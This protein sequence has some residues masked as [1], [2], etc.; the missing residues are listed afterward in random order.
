MTSHPFILT[1][2]ILAGNCFGQTIEVMNR[3]EKTS[4]T[5]A[6]FHFEQGAA[7][8]CLASGKADAAGTVQV[9]PGKFGQGITIGS[10]GIRIPAAGNLDLNRGTIEFWFRAPDVEWFEQ[11]HNFIVYDTGWCQPGNLKIWW[12][13]DGGIRFDHHSIDGGYMGFIMAG[14]PWDTK[15]HHIAARW[16]S[17]TGIA[18]FVDGVLLNAKAGSWSPV[19]TTKPSV[20]IGD[21][22][23]P[24]VMDELRISNKSLHPPGTHPVQMTIGTDAAAVTG[25]QTVLPVRVVFKNITDQPKSVLARVSIK[26]YFQQTLKEEEFQKELGADSEAAV[27][28]P[29]PVDSAGPYVKVRVKLESKTNQYKP[30]E[31]EQ[32]CFTEVLSGPRWR[33]NLNG[34]WQT[35]AGLWR[36]MEKVPATWSTSQIL[37]QKDAYWPTHAKWYRKS[38]DL[39]TGAA[40]KNVTLDL[41]GVRF[42]A[43]V[44]LNG[45]PLGQYDTDQ[46]P[47][48]VDLTPA[49]KSGQTNELVLGVTDWVSCT[50]PED[51]D[52]FTEAASDA[53]AVPGM[54]F[55]RACS[56]VVVPAGITDPI[57]VTIHSPVSIQDV[58][59]TPSVRQKNLHVRMV[60]KNASDAEAAVKPRLSILAEGKQVKEAD[61]AEVR[62]AAGETRNVE[63]D[64][65]WSDARMWWPH[66]PYLY[67]LRTELH[68]NG[69]AIDRMDTRFGFREFW[70][71]GPVFRLNGTAI[72]PRAG[73]CW[74]WGLGSI[75]GVG[76]QSLV[77]NWDKTVRS[78]RALKGINMNLFRYHTE[79]HPI[80]MYD[81]ADEVGLMLVSEGLMSSIP[82]KLK[83]ADARL[84]ENLRQYYPRWV[85][86]EFNHPSVVIR[87]MENEVGFYLPDGGP[88]GGKKIAA[89]IEKNFKQLARKVRQ[90]DPSR[91]VMFDGG[92]P[93]F[94]DVADITNF[95]YPTGEKRF[96]RFPESLR[97]IDEALPIYHLKKW[98]W[99]RNRP[100]YIGESAFYASNGPEFYAT[101]LGD[102]AYVG[103]WYTLGQTTVWKW[104]I[105]AARMDGVTAYYPWDVTWQSGGDFGEANPRARVYRISNTLIATLIPE[106]RS[107]YYGGRTIKRTLHTF[108]DSVFAAD[109]R[110]RWTL[111]ADKRVLLSGEKTLTLQPAET[112][113]TPVDLTLPVVTS[114]TDCRFVVETSVGTTL[115][116]RE[117]RTISIFPEDKAMP[118]CP[119][120]V[121]VVG[122]D[123]KGVNREK[124]AEFLNQGGRL[125]VV[126]QKKSPDWLPV[127]LTMAPEADSARTIV[128]PQ[129]V[130]HPVFASLR[131]EDLRFWREDELTVAKSYL[132]PEAITSRSLAGGGSGLQQAVILEI[133]YGRGLIF[134]VQ[135]PLFDAI[136]DQPAAKIMLGNI[137]RYLETAK[138][139]PA[140]PFGVVASDKSTLSD[141]LASVNL[142]FFNIADKL[143]QI[144]SLDG[145]GTVLV[146]GDDK[147]ADMVCSNRDLF[148]K[149]VE[150]GGTVW[151]HGFSKASFRKIA[152]LLNR[153]IEL[154][155]IRLESPIRLARRDLVTGIA[156]HTVYWPN[157]TDILSS[158]SDRVAGLVV[159]DGGDTNVMHLADPAVLAVVRSGKGRW[160]I[161]QITWD[162][163]YVQAPRARQFLLGLLTNLGYQIHQPANADQFNPA[164]GF[165][166]VDIASLCNEGFLGGIWARGGTDGLKQVPLGRQIFKGIPYEIVDPGKN[167]SKSCIVMYSRNSQDG[168]KNA[169]V[170]IA[171]KAAGV[172]VLLT[173]LWSRSLAFGTGIMKVRLH[174]ADKTSSEHV[175]RYGQDVLDWFTPP[176]DH[177]KTAWIGP[178]YP[179]PGLY[180]YFIEN[181]HPEK[182]VHHLEFVPAHEAAFAVILGVTSQDQVAR[183]GQTREW[184]PGM[185]EEMKDKR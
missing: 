95:H 53:G 167:R 161:D 25:N 93:I 102:D 112:V 30:V 33:L 180:N 172:N 170:P 150:N 45:K 123:A 16:D 104:T 107:N 79:P 151:L 40:G 52:K 21:S 158:V 74:P 19:A 154:K 169:V 136:D 122:P 133:P 118:A 130:E 88:V 162:R 143:G 41:S 26:S 60:L 135:F 39:P 23:G 61:G 128:H 55:I 29:V 67:Q 127:K 168:A 119:A 15:W 11:A 90:L 113:V 142:P 147:T 155:R 108:N 184:V 59:V 139:A 10:G 179:Q 160:L 70:C 65:P 171:R 24:C 144:R 62:L 37:P 49:V 117:E 80:L 103:D 36:E 134:L 57:F 71:D 120:G 87:S 101:Y 163:E 75:A 148:T 110:V 185:P 43:H 177:P 83:W 82:F 22:L 99:K 109:V 94:D 73:A 8:D 20:V 183:K 173:S 47:L 34:T 152:P 84:W 91:P 129:A 131:P 12:W 3:P 114:R 116:H 32:P 42:R 98:E 86:R 64:I 78:L 149:Y 35:Q 100:L 178:E 5:T 146:E 28:I 50:P 141:V 115:Q 164:L 76:E 106:Y 166:T 165:H 157:T 56:G 7:A 174:Y 14:L 153:Q 1:F 9:V 66:D 6:L 13:P 111:T 48:R 51:A 27:T 121:M 58:Y 85:A 140:N 68:Q 17:T 69:N 38:F 126:N 125:L 4:V 63:I 97:W 138:T 2:L 96:N 81:A 54:P 72:R 46:M 176:P 132:K 89:V 137:Y 105:E 92:G 31:Y 159:D 175:V 181:A 124:I 182:D 156:N 44:F 145:Y 77:T 18:L